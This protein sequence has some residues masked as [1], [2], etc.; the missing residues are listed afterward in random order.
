MKAVKFNSAGPDASCSYYEGQEAVL[1]NIAILSDA[2]RAHANLK[3]GHKTWGMV[4][5]MEFVNKRLVEVLDFLNVS[6]VRQRGE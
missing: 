2:L 3:G 1:A 5:D 6:P 4:G